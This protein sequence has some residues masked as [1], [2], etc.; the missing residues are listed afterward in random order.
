MYSSLMRQLVDRLLQLDG[1]QR[2]SI[3]TLLKHPLLRAEIP[4]LLDSVT[5]KEEFSHTLLHSRDVF[6]ELKTKKKQEEKKDEEQTAPN[7]TPD[8]KPEN[9]LDPGILAEELNDYKDHL[10]AAKGRPK[11]AINEYDAGKVDLAPEVSVVA[12]VDEEQEEMP[13]E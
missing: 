11:R 2:P 8:Y 6:A 13:T 4:R 5:F 7:F 10:D 3:N 9:G 1:A 12:E